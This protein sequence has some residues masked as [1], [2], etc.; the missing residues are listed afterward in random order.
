MCATDDH[1]QVPS[2]LRVTVCVEDN[3]CNGRPLPGVG[4]CASRTAASDSRL[5]PKKLPGA[6]GGLGLKSAS[7]VTS[8]SGAV[9]DPAAAVASAG[10]G[11]DP[12]APFAGA[13][14]ESNVAAS[15]R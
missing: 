4:A 2:K 3:V 1:C 9:A 6:V 11:A 7:L 14:S 12:A 8:C 10:S 13:R 15:C 5:S